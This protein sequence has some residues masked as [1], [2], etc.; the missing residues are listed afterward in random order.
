MLAAAKAAFLPEFLNRID[1]IVTFE[2]LG[3]EHVE[4]IARLIVGRVADRL[5][6]ERGIE[7]TVTDALVARLAQDGF[8]AEYGARP[9]ARH[10][11]RTLEREL[12]AAIVDGRLG[13]GA[14]VTADVD[15]DGGVT[16]ALAAE[17]V[18]A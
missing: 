11:R 18:A 10:V 9:L 5:R 4:R 15:A 12:T 7:L 2:A 16:L 17:A 1:E 13:D 14:A 6:T 8:D 3:G